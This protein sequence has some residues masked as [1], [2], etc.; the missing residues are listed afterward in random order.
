MKPLVA[1]TLAMDCVPWPWPGSVL[2][3]ALVLPSPPHAVSMQADATA[4]KTRIQRTLPFLLQNVGTCPFDQG[5]RNNVRELFL[6]EARPVLDD[7]MTILCR[8]AVST[9]TDYYILLQS[10][11]NYVS[12]YGCL[13]I[14]NVR[15]FMLCFC[16]RMY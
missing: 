15:E 13:N 2:V 4:I 16:L 7:D 12:V 8:G 11:L 10:E 5:G 9:K 14:V 6:R 3:P 1:T